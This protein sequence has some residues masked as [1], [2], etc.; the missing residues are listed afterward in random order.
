MQGEAG[1]LE[2]VSAGQ[3]SQSAL[4]VAPDAGLV[5]P[6]GQLRHA[7]RSLVPWSGLKVPAGH[8][9]HTRAVAAPASAQ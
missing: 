2:Y 1:S 8:E 5:V 9:F 6:R 4:L 3:A 7:E